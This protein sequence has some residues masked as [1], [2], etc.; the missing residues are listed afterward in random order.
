M[1]VARRLVW[2]V[3]VSDVV[4][5]YPN[6]TVMTGDTPIAQGPRPVSDTVAVTMG[7]A[8]RFGRQPSRAAGPV[9]RAVRS[10]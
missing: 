8:W 7:V 9:R 10:K 1:T 5:F 6:K 3:D 4:T 2:R